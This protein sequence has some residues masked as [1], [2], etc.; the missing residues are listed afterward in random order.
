MSTSHLRPAED[1]DHSTISDSDSDHTR[2]DDLILRREHARQSA[3]PQRRSLDEEDAGS[4]G[5]EIPPMKRADEGQIVTWMSL[6]RKGQLALLTF[7]RLSE[8]LVQS[9]LRVSNTIP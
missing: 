8:P 6:P 4:L 3:V 5:L 2:S 1:H 7:A 9:S